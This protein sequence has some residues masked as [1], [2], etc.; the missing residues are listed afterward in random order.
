MENTPKLTLCDA[1]EKDAPKRGIVEIRNFSDGN[2]TIIGHYPVD[3]D[4]EPFY[5]GMLIVPTNQGQLKLAVEFPEGQDLAL[6][7][8]QFEERA[9]EVFETFKKKVEEENLI[10]TPGGMQQPQSIIT[11]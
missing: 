8:D 7:F 2:N 10:A 6:C 11:P 9:E 5:I 1:P 3:S 4:A